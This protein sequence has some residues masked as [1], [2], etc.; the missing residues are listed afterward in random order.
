[1]LYDTVHYRRLGYI[2]GYSDRMAG[3]RRTRRRSGEGSI[4]QRASDGRWVG[5]VNLG[6]VEGKRKRVT[7]TAATHREALHKMRKAQQ[8]VTAGVTVTRSATVEGW[9]T[10]WLDDIA[11]HKVKDATLDTYR[12]YIFRELVP[13]LGTVKLDRL[14]AEHVRG[15]HQ[16]MRRRG[17]SPTTIRQAHTILQRALRV[18]VSDGL[19]VRNVAQAVSAPTAARNPHPILTADDARKVLMMSAGERDLCRLVCA[20]LLGLRQGEALGL[21]W[22]DVALVGDIGTV[23]VRRTVSRIRGR[24]LVV[25][26]PKTERSA[27]SVPLIPHAALAFAA[28]RQESGGRGFVFHGHG[29]PDVPEGPERDHRAWKVALARAGVPA[30]PL[31]G[32]RGSAATLLSQLGVPERVIADIVGHATVRTTLAH[33][34]HSDEAQRRQALESLGAVLMLPGGLSE[35]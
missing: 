6:W 8:A 9:L 3:Q 14:T 27:R 18:A 20:L 11:A 26:T 13:V 30:V 29:G 24:G 25:G 10:Y 22:E 7:V 34:L 28:W 17:C 21:R 35:S 16:A 31:H 4:Y 19:A 32:A 12:R 1:M 5:A 15:L 33:Y 2:P 23:S